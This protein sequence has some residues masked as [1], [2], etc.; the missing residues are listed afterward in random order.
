MIL[1]IEM[2]CSF[3][4]LILIGVMYRI[5]DHKYPCVSV[6]IKGQKN[7]KEYNTDELLIS[8]PTHM[9]DVNIITGISEPVVLGTVIFPSNFPQI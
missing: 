6:H 5:T 2:F 4:S 9:P 3:L 8:N 1:E 7:I